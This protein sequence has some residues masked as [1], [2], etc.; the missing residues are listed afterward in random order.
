VEHRLFNT[1]AT[2][3]DIWQFNEQSGYWRGVI[4]GVAISVDVEAEGAIV[5]WQSL[6]VDR[7]LD[8]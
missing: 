6:T 5:V 1:R 2:V 8:I 7:Y 3:G 4:T